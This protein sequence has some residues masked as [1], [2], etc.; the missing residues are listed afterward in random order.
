MTNVSKNTDGDENFSLAQNQLIKFIG[1]LQKTNSQYFLNELLTQSEQIMIVKRFAAV[2][3]YAESYSP[4]RVSNTLTISIS[5]AQRIYADYQNGTYT[6]LLSCV[7]HKETN[8]FLLLIQDLI[9]A[10]VSPRARARLLNQV[11]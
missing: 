3:M 2:F 8:S 4:Y 5:T 7:T 9:L 11:L 1:D 10:Q 6:K